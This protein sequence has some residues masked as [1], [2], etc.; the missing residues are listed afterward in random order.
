MLFY[1][2][3][4]RDKSCR[5]INCNYFNLTFLYCNPIIVS[6]KTLNI[7]KLI[8]VSNRIMQYQSCIFIDMYN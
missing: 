1:R 7:K 2:L 3:L 8:I 5:G 4:R 6:L